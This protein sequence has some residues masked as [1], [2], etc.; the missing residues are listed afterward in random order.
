MLGN[1]R[2]THIR[3]APRPTPPPAQAA[4]PAPD[5]AVLLTP[6]EAARRLGVQERVLERWRSTGGG[7][8]YAKLG[9]KTLR[10][11]ASDLEA[12]IAGSVR[13]STAG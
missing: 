1:N 8:Q 3:T 12:F 13:R 10:Y 6:A 7:P 9:G 2:P 11:R 5:D 4:K